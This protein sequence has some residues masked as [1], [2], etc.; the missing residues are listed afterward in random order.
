M[1]ARRFETV[2]TFGLLVLGSALL[3]TAAET[4]AAPKAI[5]LLRTG[6]LVD[7]ASGTVRTG[8]DV[9]IEGNR[10]KA[11]GPGLTA[12]AGAQVIDLRDKT[13]L[14]GF[15]DCHT[16]ITSQPENYYADQ[17]RKSPIDVAVSAHLYARRT[18]L[19]GFTSVR[20]AGAGEYIDVALAKAIDAG[21]IAGP[22]I[23]P[24]GLAIGATGGHG[25]LN[26]FSPYLRFEQMT[27]VADGVDEIRKLVRRNIKFGADHIKM[28]ATAGVLS[29]EESV[30]APQFSLEEM[31]ALVDE[32][33]MWHKKVMAHAHGTEGIKRAITAGVASIEH[34]SF[35]DDEAIRMLKEHG[36]YLV[37]DIYNDDYILEKYASLGFPENILEKERKVGRTQRESFKKAALAGVKMAYGTDSGVYPHGWNA[38]QFRHM[39][40]WGLTPMQAIQSATVNAADLIGT[41]TVGVIAPGRFADL[42]AV[43]GDPLADVTRLEKPA[44]VMKDGVVYLQA[45]QPALAALADPGP[46]SPTR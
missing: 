23:H 8:Q 22:R 15:I 21:K 20:E 37:A 32:A 11:V 39:V 12:P 44:F 10:I 40:E 46:A 19:A 6:R 2:A 28:I 5:L 3:A 9:L 25:D 38:K 27:N 33:A 13:V 1:N 45:G 35:L 29:E 30:G 34:G 18:L 17:F 7:T 14:P 4:P 41:D 36:T 43:D 26:G 31:K 42:V 24:A 16:H